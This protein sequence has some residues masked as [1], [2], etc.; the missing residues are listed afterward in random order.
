MA[1]AQDAITRIREQVSDDVPD[2]SGAYRWDDPMMLRL[3]W[4][5]IL[6][7]A[8]DHPE[9]LYVDSVVVTDLTDIPT[10]TAVTQTLPIR[11]EYLTSLV[12]SV[13]GRILRED[14]EDAGNL[15]L[16]E[17]HKDQS[18]EAKQ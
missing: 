5:G 11:N 9:A 4:D 15:V 14:S 2:A 16:S 12:G 10:L 3:L 18:A 1:I 7:I 13:S 8:G 17:Q 6:D